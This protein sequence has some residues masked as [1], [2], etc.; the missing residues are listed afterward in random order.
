MGKACSKDFSLDGSTA[1]SF[2]KNGTVLYKLYES[3]T[4]F[5]N[6]RDGAVQQLSPGSKVSA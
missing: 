6:G 4:D 5:G 1:S 3:A 2:N